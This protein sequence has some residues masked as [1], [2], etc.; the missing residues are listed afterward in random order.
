MPI[1]TL[2]IKAD[3]ENIDYIELIPNNLFKLDVENNGQIKEGITVSSEDLIEIDG[4]KGTANFVMKF[5]GAKQSSHISIIKNAKGTTG[6]LSQD[7][8][9]FVTIATMECRGLNIIKWHISNDFM[10]VGLTGTKFNEVDLSDEDGYADFD[11][12]TGQGVSIEAVET[13]IGR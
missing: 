8:I 12:A 10:A 5:T 1:F 13:K 9:G 3:F 4:S 11:E 2:Q 7:D 6:R